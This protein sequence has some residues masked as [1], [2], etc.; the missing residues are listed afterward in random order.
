[1]IDVEQPLA[2]KRML[3]ALENSIC[4]FFFKFLSKEVE[5]IFWES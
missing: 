5:T 1:M 3:W 2:Q 4:Q